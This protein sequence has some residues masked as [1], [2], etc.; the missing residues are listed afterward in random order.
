[1]VSKYCQAKTASRHAGPVKVAVPSTAW[2]RGQPVREAGPKYF[3]TRL[4]E[5]PVRAKNMAAK[6]IPYLVCDA[7]FHFKV[8]LSS[9][10]RY[11]MESDKN[12]ALD[13]HH[14]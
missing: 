6:V 1:M 14:F 2:D 12:W 13:A 4:Y 10:C 8:L 5:G 7:G 11:G 3:K 9:K